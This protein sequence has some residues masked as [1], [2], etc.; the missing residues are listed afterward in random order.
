MKGINQVNFVQIGPVVLEIRWIENNHFAVPVNNALVYHSSFLA[1]DTGPCVLIY[2][3]LCMH[4]D[5]CVSVESY[6]PLL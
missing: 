3:H 1:A 4:I 5:M 6:V 2:I